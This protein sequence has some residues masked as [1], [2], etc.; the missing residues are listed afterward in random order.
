MTRP[1]RT[2]P[3]TARREPSPPSRGRLAVQEA[4]SPH[5]FSQSRPLPDHICLARRAL[6]R[7]F[8]SCQTSSVAEPITSAELTSTPPASARK[9]ELLEK[10]YAYVLEHGL[11]DLS[12]RPLAHQIGSSPRVLL[13]CFDSK[14]GLVRAVL[15][16]ARADELAL[17]DTLDPECDLEE[18]CAEVWGWLADPR[19][20]ALLCLWVEAYAR[21]LTHPAGPWTDWAAGVGAGLARRARRTAVAT[22]PAYRC[23]P[24][25]THRRPCPAPRRAA[26]P[27]RYRRPPSGDSSC[28][29][30]TAAVI[31]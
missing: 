24:V 1:S 4:G 18:A 21:S 25:R 22:T 12:L 20:R 27:A 5:H 3:R 7:L 26:R 2:P 19:H 9:A 13:F 10:T 6:T 30:V 14:D 31:G 15:A 17:L 29:R 11:S 23:R 28:R 16:R 8:Q